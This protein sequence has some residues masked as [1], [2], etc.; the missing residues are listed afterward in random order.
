MPH[1]G[2]SRKPP[3]SAQLGGLPTFGEPYGKP[4]AIRLA[5]LRHLIEHC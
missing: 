5:R 3:G 4:S 1:Y 2:H